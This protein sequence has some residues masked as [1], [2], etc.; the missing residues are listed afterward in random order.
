MSSLLFSFSTLKW[1]PHSWFSLRRLSNSVLSVSLE[2]L[3]YE[4]KTFS[5]S[6]PWTVNPFLCLLSRTTKSFSF[7]SPVVELSIYPF[8]GCQNSFLGVNISIYVTLNTKLIPY[9][10]HPKSLSYHLKNPSKLIFLLQ[11]VNPR[12]AGSAPSW[13]SKDPCWRVITR[14]A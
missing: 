7:F 11:N 6:L 5:L 4:P 2:T 10:I 14:S 1:P 12:L 8:V 3:Y 13:W 9:S